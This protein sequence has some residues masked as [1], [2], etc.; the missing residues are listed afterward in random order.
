M[1]TVN[2]RE[3][4]KS[5]PKYLNEVIK[6]MDS[7]LSKAQLR[8]K[9]LEDLIDNSTQSEL[10]ELKDK[11]AMLNK[12]AF[13]G[14][15]SLNRHRLDEKLKESFFLTISPHLKEKLLQISKEIFQKLRSFMKK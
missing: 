4:L 13:G 8:I 15:E 2:L 9:E 7:S 10:I 14:S 11:I 3:D 6:V 1:S 12:Q 5:D